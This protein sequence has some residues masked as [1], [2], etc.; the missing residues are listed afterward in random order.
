MNKKMYS[1]KIK[2]FIKNHLKII[3]SRGILKMFYLNI[4]TESIIFY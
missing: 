2:I 3:Y 4:F 1:N